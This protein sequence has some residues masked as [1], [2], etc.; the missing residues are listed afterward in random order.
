LSTPADRQIVFVCQHGAFRSRLAAAYFNEVAPKGWH[1]ISAGVTPQSQ[2]SERV[3]PMLHGTDASGF[4]D[5]DPPRSLDAVSGSLT[6]AIDVELPGAETWIT[7]TDDAGLS[8][9][10][11]RDVIRGRVHD[12]VGQLGGPAAEQQSLP[13]G[14]RRDGHAQS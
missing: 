11:L 13:G 10:E 2:V 5:V 8:D 4:V 6:I 3:A 14:Q 9:P 7:T 1:A 12:F